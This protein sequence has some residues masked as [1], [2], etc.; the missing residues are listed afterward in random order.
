MQLEARSCADESSRGRV[1]KCRASSS[2]I[3]SLCSG[4]GSGKRSSKSGR[5]MVSAKC[6]QKRPA[7]S[8]MRTIA[9][10]SAQTYG[11]TSGFG[12]RGMSPE[13]GST[14]PYMSAATCVRAALPLPVP[15]RVDDP[16]V[17]AAEVVVR[18]TQ[19]LA[20][21]VEEAGEEDVGARDEAVQKLAAGGFGEVQA[22]AALV[23]PELL[24]DEVPAGRSR[25]EPAGDE[26]PDRIAEARGLH[27]DHL[28]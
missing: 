7:C 1:A 11:P 16:W 23:A 26:S 24:D 18:E 5:S 20:R 13:D 3:A 9:L 19:P 21:V 2:R 10:P 4:D 8:I 28:G 25:D 14:K 27:L 12:G 17:H 22:D 6:G 15:A